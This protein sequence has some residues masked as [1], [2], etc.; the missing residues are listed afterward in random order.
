MANC[1]HKQKEDPKE[2]IP[3]TNQELVQDNKKENTLNCS[4]TP[5]YNTILENSKELQELLTYNAVKYHL[6]KVYRILTIQ[7]GAGITDNEAKRDLAI[8]YLNTLRVGGIH[9]NEAVEE[10]CQ[11]ASQKLFN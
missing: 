5:E 3:D 6:H 4:Q 9:H 8:E 10:F 11:L 2:K 7:N 1:E